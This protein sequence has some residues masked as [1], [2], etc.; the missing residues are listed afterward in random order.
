M[1][2]ATRTSCYPH[3]TWYLVLPQPVHPASDACST[4]GQARGGAGGRGGS[5]DCAKSGGLAGRGRA[6]T[7]IRPGARLSKMTEETFTLEHRPQTPTPWSPL[8]RRAAGGD[9][10]RHAPAR[11]RP[12]RRSSAPPWY[13]RPCAQRQLQAPGSPA[14]GRR[15]HAERAASAL[16]ADRGQVL[17]QWDPG[18]GLA[19]EG[20]VALLAKRETYSLLRS[21]RRSPWTEQPTVLEDLD[22]N[23]VPRMGPEVGDHLPGHAGEPGRGR[24][25]QADR[26]GLRALRADVHARPSCPE[27]WPRSPA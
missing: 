2:R 23:A 20:F 7:S 18:R 14:R 13:R 3:R 27:G 15:R 22:Q 19:L 24:A 10:Q 5:V 16:F 21:R 4:T 12:F 6:G 1:H 17:Q 26:Q 9:R 11:G 25:H 8:I